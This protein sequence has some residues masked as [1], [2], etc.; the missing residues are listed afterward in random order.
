MA[1]L[2]S[3]RTNT[4]GIGEAPCSVAVPILTRLNGIHPLAKTIV[5]A[6]SFL[7]CGRVRNSIENFLAEQLRKSDQV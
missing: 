4:L 7:G 1:S 5:D 2:W 6:L 3:Q